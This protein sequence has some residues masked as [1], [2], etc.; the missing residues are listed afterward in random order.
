MPTLTARLVGGPTA[1][2]EYA[3]LR[4]LTDPALSPPG[5]YA[6]GLVK[7]AGP[8]LDS[9]SVGLIDVVLLSHQHHSDNLD[10]AGRA[11]WKRRGHGPGDRLPPPRR[12]AADGLRVGR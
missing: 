2:L 3:G 10:P 1:I 7:T 12:R 9:D 5:E 8:A 4:W 11:R 6:G